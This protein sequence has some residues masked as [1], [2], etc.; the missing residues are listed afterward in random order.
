M[1]EVRLL[2]YTVDAFSEYNESKWIEGAEKAVAYDRANPPKD[3][4]KTKPTIEQTSLNS[5]D[6]RPARVQLSMKMRK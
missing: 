3:V 1:R 4:A 6:S 5:D 2:Q